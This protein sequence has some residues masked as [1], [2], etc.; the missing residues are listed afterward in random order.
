MLEEGRSDLVGLYLMMD[1]KLKELGFLDDPDEAARAAYEQYV[2]NAVI[3]QPR[4]TPVYASD[5]KITDVRISY[6]M[7]MEQ[8]MLELL[9]RVRPSH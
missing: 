6:P 1:P 9:G 8:Q 4:L 2:L 5:G 3:Q 7:S